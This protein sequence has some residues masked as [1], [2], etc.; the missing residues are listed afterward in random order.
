[1]WRAL[2]TA[3]QTEFLAA[4]DLRAEGY[5][6]FLPFVRTKVRVKLPTRGRAL[7]KAVTREEPRWPRYLFTYA[8][9]AA[10]AMKASRHVRG[11]VGFGGEAAKISER[12]IDALRRACD[13]DG[14]VVRP[15]LLYE[16]GDV[17]KILAPSPLAGREGVVLW[18]SDAVVTMN[19][20]G[21][22]VVS[23]FGET[24]PISH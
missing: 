22:T 8:E 20:E 11:I 9:N 13:K 19:V 24:A 6:V 14:R 17:L 21:L 5:D 7:F 15:S 16:I 1:M 3:G 10:E 12:T 4:K 2:T 18:L 23:P